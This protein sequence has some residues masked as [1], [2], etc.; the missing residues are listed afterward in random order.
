MRL[1]FNVDF[2]RAVFAVALAVLLYF[3]ALNE[4][5]PES[6]NLTN[7]TIPVLPV[8]VPTGLVVTTAPSPIKL[9]LRAP[10]SVFG[11]L[12]ADSF[13]AQV[14]TSTAVAG[15]NDNLPVVVNWT[16]PDVRQADAEPATLRLHLEEIRTQTLPVRV[17]L[18]GQVPQQYL[19]GQAT[20]DP[21]QMTISGAASLVGQA[22]EAVVDVSVDRVTVPIN[23]VYT[24]RILDSRGNDLK[25]LNLR[26]SPP[27]LS[28]QVPITQQTQYKEVGVHT[29]TQG[30]P[31]VGY[32]VQPLEVNPP[33]ATLVGDS[34][35][36]ESANFIDTVPIDI[37][38]ISTT[39]VRNVALAPPV[40][41]ILL[42]QGQTVTVTVRVT[43]LSVKQTVR[44]P[45]SVINLSGTVQLAHPLDLVSVTIS[46][47]APA[48][49]SLALNPKDF[50]VVLDVSGKGP[51]RSTVDAK[52][53]QVPTGLTLEDFAPKQVQ[54]D[55]TEAPT[56]SPVPSASPPPGG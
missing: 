22:T 44:V 41:T 28:V 2:G 54:V 35:A 49:S 6:R 15:D 10:S 46:G 20:V 16:D 34:A 33:T 12:H 45:P 7:F 23:G 24:P 56:P 4:T 19:L 18:T 26:T 51:G 11:R 1:P 14:D 17:N 31:A 25:D 38:G 50:K 32:V 30:Q 47:P 3:V 21:P 43:T 40:K 27:S 42:Q 39:V 13:T 55:L 29:V 53:L 5:N 36:L 52:V 37:N 9:W 48:L 8:N